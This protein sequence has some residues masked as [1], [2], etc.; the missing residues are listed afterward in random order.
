M[1]NR[2]TAPAAEAGAAAPEGG[3]Q[4]AVHTRAQAVPAKPPH[5]QPTQLPPRDKHTGKGGTYTRDPITG[6]RTPT[7]PQA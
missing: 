6:E 5:H 2:R 1:T 4:A 7:E 3:E